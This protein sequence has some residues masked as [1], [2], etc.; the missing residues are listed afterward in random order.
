LDNLFLRDRQQGTTVKLTNNTSSL[1]CAAAMTPDGRFVAIMEPGTPGKL[2]V[3]NS[4]SNTMVRVNSNLITTALSPVVAISP[5]GRR[6][7]YAAKGDSG[8]VYAA[9]WQTDTRIM[10]NTYPLDSMPRLKFS[11]D[12]RFLVY[13]V[14]AAVKYVYLYDFVSF[15]NQLISGNWESNGISTRS[16]SPDISADGRFIVYRS[17]SANLA[18]VNNPGFNEVFVYDRAT[19]TTTLLSQGRSENGELDHRSAY[20][21]FS[22]DGKTIV[23]QSRASNLVSQDLNQSADVFA[24]RF[25][26]ASLIPGTDGTWISWPCS[27]ETTY[28][29]Q[30]KDSLEDP[31]WLDLGGSPTNSGNNAYQKDANAP[32]GHRFY[33]INAQ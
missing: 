12:G 15:S 24:Y 21:I 17:E 20:P 32:V 2:L 18:L 30:Y 16:D 7:I 33:R 29:V 22:G 8:P 4:Q 31:E 25:L 11:R 23:F 6:I 27:P 5:D 1:P 28:R 14:S 9:D 26:S 10:I 19:A 3:W 13:A